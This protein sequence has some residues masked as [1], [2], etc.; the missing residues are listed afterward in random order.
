MERLLLV[1]VERLCARSRDTP[2]E[3]ALPGRLYGG[4]GFTYTNWLDCFCL[5][6]I[7]AFYRLPDNPSSLP[8]AACY[9][10]P[11]TPAAG[12]IKSRQG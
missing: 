1:P 3:D 4:Y 7:S 9:S 12:L 8:D 5:I 2:P 6:P 11:P 10:Y